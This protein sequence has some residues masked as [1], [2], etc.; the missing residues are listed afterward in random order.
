V[1][2]NH[3]DHYQTYSAISYGS[4]LITWFRHVA[5]ISTFVSTYRRDSLASPLPTY[6]L[7]QIESAQV[8]PSTTELSTESQTD[9]IQ[10]HPF[11]L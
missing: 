7:Q 3:A 4:D 6:L 1:S 8:S 11:A 2:R 5:G 10:A 9:L